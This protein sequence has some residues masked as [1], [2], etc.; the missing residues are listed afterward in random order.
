MF[1]NAF[2]A[3]MVAFGEKDSE[4]LAT[5]P[6][7]GVLLDKKCAQSDKLSWIAKDSIKS[8]REREE[9][10]TCYVL[11]STPEY[12][13][14]IIK[15]VTQCLGAEGTSKGVREAVARAA[16]E[17]LLPPFLDLVEDHLQMKRGSLVIKP[18]FIKGH[19][20]GAA[21]PLQA[22]IKSDGSSSLPAQQ[23]YHIDVEAKFIAIGDY[24]P[25]NDGGFA[26]I[27]GATLSGV[28]AAKSLL[29]PLKN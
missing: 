3:T 11:H 15:D 25:R 12:A 16:E 18:S 8:G 9:K 20:W 6:F 5:F 23:S 14:E 7:H 29:T 21:F 26:R 22:I 2:L 27:E 13:M 17:L 19:R 10:K 24:L 1:V 28:S 4:I